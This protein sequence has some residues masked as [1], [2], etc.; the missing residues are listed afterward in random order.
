MLLVRIPRGLCSTGGGSSAKTRHTQMSV[1]GNPFWNAVAWEGQGEAAGLAGWA[2]QAARPQ[3]L[4]PCAFNAPSQSFLPCAKPLRTA[5]P[6]GGTLLWAKITSF[7]TPLTSTL[8]CWCSS[9]QVLRLFSWFRSKPSELSG[10]PC[11]PAWLRLGLFLKYPLLVY[12]KNV[13]LYQLVLK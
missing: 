5:V 13:Q 11:F 6:S 2:Q 12:G 7:P 8:P 1:W 3:E 9:Y 10:D 4:L